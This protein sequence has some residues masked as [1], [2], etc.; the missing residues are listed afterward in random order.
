MSLDINFRPMLT[1][2]LNHLDCALVLEDSNRTIVFA[3][4]LFSRLWN[5]PLDEVL[6]QNGYTITERLQTLFSDSCVFNRLVSEALDRREILTGI[7]LRLTDNRIISFDYTPVYIGDVFQGHLWQMRDISARKEAEAV[8]LH[9]AYHDALTGLPNRLLFQDRLAIALSQAEREAKLMALIF[10]DCYQFKQ[11][12]DT[13][14]HLCGDRLLQIVAERLIES[15][16][17]GDT[18]ARLGGDEFIIILPRIK[19]YDEVQSVAKRILTAF[20]QPVIFNDTPAE[21]GASIGISVYPHDATTA[22][23][24]LLAA[25]TA[26]YQ[27][28]ALGSYAYHFYQRPNK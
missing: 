15:V 1:A 8:I 25:D 27:S 26:M 17:K 19:N 22:D 6:G 12:N 23:G 5:L 16:R 20:R 21:L 24:L 2:I 9:R 13:F 28:K 14:G 10:L 7:E 11:I 4:Q 3:N 18:V